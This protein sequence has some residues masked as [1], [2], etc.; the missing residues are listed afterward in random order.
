M[1][2]TPMTNAT[3]AET[4]PIPRLMPVG[5]P[6]HAGWKPPETRQYRVKPERIVSTAATG[7]MFSM[8]RRCSACIPDAGDQQPRHEEQRAGPEYA[9][10][11]V[12]Q[13]QDDH[14]GIHRRDPPLEGGQEL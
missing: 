9:E 12:Q 2:N 3:M 1:T 4:A 7:T 14:E 11:H 13:S 6:D 8:P 5:E 10:Y